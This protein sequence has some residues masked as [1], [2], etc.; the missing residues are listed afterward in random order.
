MTLVVLVLSAIIGAWARET[1]D[2]AAGPALR[3]LAGSIAIIFGSI[4]IGAGIELL[5]RG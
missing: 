3:I 4:A 2:H 5:F 1:H